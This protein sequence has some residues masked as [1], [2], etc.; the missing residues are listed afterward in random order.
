VRTGS[1]LRGHGAALCG[2]G[3]RPSGNLK[4]KDV[5]LKIALALF[6]VYAI[7]LWIGMVNATMLQL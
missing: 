4:E 5:A 3:R 1:G 7:V 2:A 6:A